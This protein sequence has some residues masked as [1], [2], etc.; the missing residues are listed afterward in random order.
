MPRAEADTAAGGAVTPDAWLAGESGKVGLL[1]S[2]D[3]VD[4]IEAAAN[5]ESDQPPS[6]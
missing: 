2:D 4:W 1:L 6:P 5:D 3:A